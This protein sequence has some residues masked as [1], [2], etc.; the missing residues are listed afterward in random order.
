MRSMQSIE[1]SRIYS[2]MQ[3]YISK[4]LKVAIWSLIITFLLITL[5]F[6]NELSG[7]LE[8]LK[9]IDVLDSL[10]KLGLVTAIA[11]FLLEIPQRAEQ[12]KI[13]AEKK[14]FE[15]WRAIDAAAVPKAS[16]WNSRFKSF[17]LRMALEKLNKEKDESGNQIKMHG[18]DVSNADLS[19]IDLSNADLVDSQ[20][21]YTDLSNARF[22]EANLQRVSF[23][24]ARL[25]NTDFSNADLTQADFRDA[26]CDEKTLAS[27]G[28]KFDP[29]DFG[30]YKIA[31][32]SNLQYADLEMGMLWG[33]DLKNANLQ[34]A[35]GPLR[36]EYA[37]LIEAELQNSDL[38]GSRG[39]FA[40]FHA[41]NLDN[42]NLSES[43]FRH[44]NFSESSM[45]NVNLSKT[46][47]RHADLRSA[48]LCEANLQSA[49]LSEAKLNNSNVDGAN[50][51]KA[52]IRGA[53][54]RGVK[55]IRKEQI[56]DA[57]FWDMALFDD[58]FYEQIHA[59]LDEKTG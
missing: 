32:G 28:G 53:D 58:G 26:L 22:C 38:S 20:F 39:L 13:E 29:K 42:S 19:E 47:L 45:C 14:R 4:Y 55:N 43:R 11:T 30:A 23:R 46:D 12:V 7:W 10:G 44:A 8:K 40:N 56:Q 25:F 37:S 2:E 35:N 41:A 31:A 15:Y 16:G 52:N 27:F 54:F 50:F 49:D 33:A 5:F 59:S 34:R 6:S 57:K 3:R 1:K 24:Q 48:K 18:V 9:F 17:A 51:Y 21:R 36:I